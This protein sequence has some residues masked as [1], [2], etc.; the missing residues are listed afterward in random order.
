MRGFDASNR[1][2]SFGLRSAG[3]VD[4]SIVRIEELGELCAKT[5]IST[6]DNE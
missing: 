2:R 4:H 6:G 1:R 5:S 3:N